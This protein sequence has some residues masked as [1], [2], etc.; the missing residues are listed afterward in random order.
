LSW[1][2][3]R[4]RRRGGRTRPQGWNRSWLGRG[5]RGVTQM[6]R[7]LRNLEDPEGGREQGAGS[8]KQD[9]RDQG[10]ESGGVPWSFELGKQTP[11]PGPDFGSRDPTHGTSG[12]FSLTHCAA[13]GPGSAIATSSARGVRYRICGVSAP[14]HRGCATAGRRKL[15]SKYS[16]HVVDV[17]LAHPTTAERR[18]TELLA[19]CCC[20]RH[21]ALLV[22]L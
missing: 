12:M 7:S 22:T 8:R 17:V 21:V 15:R 20:R 13:S 18:D 3:L 16:T 9:R 2:L 11:D 10:D 19:C 1:R 14:S 5:Q 4:R 6:T